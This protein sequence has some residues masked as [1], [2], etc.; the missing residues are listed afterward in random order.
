MVAIRRYVL[1]ATFHLF[2]FFNVCKENT[3]YVSIDFKGLV[4]LE[5]YLNS[6]A[7]L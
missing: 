5:F 6:G 2:F 7:T 4:E 1:C 3:S